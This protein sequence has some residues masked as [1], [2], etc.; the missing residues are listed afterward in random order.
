[1]EIIDDTDHLLRLKLITHLDTIELLRHPVDDETTVTRLRV[2][3]S[4][5]TSFYDWN[6][7]DLREGGRD[8]QDIK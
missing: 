4:E 3:L 6:T 8:N 1:M 2:F 7:N 5:I